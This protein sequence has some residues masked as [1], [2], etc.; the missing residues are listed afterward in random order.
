MLDS[1]LGGQG[2]LW[3]STHRIPYALASFEVPQVIDAL[4]MMLGL[5]VYDGVERLQLPVG[6]I[7]RINVG[8]ASVGKPHSDF[9]ADR[10]YGHL[11]LLKGQYP[12]GAA[13]TDYPLTIV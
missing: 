12:S 5:T 8:S 7:D 9:Q 10:R 11:L 6:R 2:Q 4:R 3:I 13:R 1:Q